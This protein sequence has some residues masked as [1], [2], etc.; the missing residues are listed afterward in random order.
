MPI[1]Y[2]RREGEQ[3]EGGAV[4]EPFGLSRGERLQMSG[5]NKLQEH[6]VTAERGVEDEDGAVPSMCCIMTSQNRFSHLER[7]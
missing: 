5:G 4:R 3:R 2:R 1:L 6:S 7:K